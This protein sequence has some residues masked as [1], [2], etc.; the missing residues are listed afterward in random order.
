VY[1]PHIYIYIYI[2]KTCCD[3]YMVCSVCVKEKKIWNKGAVCVRAV[4]VL[5]EERLL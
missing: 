1:F 2:Y 5:V 4:S 3:G